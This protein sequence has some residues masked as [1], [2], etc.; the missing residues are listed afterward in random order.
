MLDTTQHKTRQAK[1]KKG[2]IKEKMNLIRQY[3]KN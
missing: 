3:V 1:W 2:S